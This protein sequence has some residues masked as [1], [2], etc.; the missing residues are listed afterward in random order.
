MTSLENKDISFTTN[1]NN[2]ASV[3]KIFTGAAVY[4]ENKVCAS[5][6]NHELFS[7]EGDR[8][9]I[10]YKKLSPA[11]ISDTLQLNFVKSK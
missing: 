10:E 2:C 7:M 5:F 3:T 9:Y 8:A 4:K 6:Q 11:V 1:Q